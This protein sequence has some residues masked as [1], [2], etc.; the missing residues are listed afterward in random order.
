MMDTQLP[1]MT[2]EEWNYLAYCSK[3]VGEILLLGNTGP[4]GAEIEQMQ[5]AL[6]RFSDKINTHNKLEGVRNE[7]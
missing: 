5:A 7:K 3:A 2:Q 1:E 6:L 4:Y